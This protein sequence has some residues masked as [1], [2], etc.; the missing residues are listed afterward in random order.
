MKAK[1]AK[2]ITALVNQNSTVGTKQRVL[3]SLR[4]QVKMGVTQLAAAKKSA[5]TALT[6][7]NNVLKKADKK[8]TDASN[9]KK[10]ITKAEQ[11]LA[12]ARR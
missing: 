10:R 5:R 8:I 11:A 9:K 12:K 2:Q 7:T 1:T 4:R 6:K 3:D